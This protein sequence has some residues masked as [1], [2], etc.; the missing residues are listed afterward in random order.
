MPMCIERVD[1]VRADAYTIE[2]FRDE[3]GRPRGRVV[4]PTHGAPRSVSS[5]VSPDQAIEIAVQ[6]ARRDR[7]KVVVWDPDGLWPADWGELIQA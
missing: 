1:D 4:P 7:A 2:L 6:L 5:E 3:D